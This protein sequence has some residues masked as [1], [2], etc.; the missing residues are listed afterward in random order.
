MKEIVNK[1]GVDYLRFDE[2]LRLSPTIL[3]SPFN[4]TIKPGQSIRKI[5]R[6]NRSCFELLPGHLM[7]YEGLLKLD[8]STYAIFHC[9]AHDQK[10]LSL[11]GNGIQSRYA[12]ACVFVEGH[13]QCFLVGKGGPAGMRDIQM[14]FI[15]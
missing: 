8:G 7:T 14:D 15:T 5:G 13:F 4:V 12:F 1:W 9:P 2:Q 10:Q 11:F 6:K 3:T